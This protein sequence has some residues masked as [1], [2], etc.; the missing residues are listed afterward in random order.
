MTAT[1]KRLL[2]SES[3][4]D[5]SRCTPCR[6]NPDQHA[7]RFRRSVRVWS[8]TIRISHGSHIATFHTVVNKFEQIHYPREEGLLTQSTTR[9]LTDPQV[10]TQLLSHNSQ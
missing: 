7:T 5:S 3:R 9:R 10:H 6:G 2:I 1:T 8:K 4:G